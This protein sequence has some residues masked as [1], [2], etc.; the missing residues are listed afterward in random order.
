[1]KRSFDSTFRW[2]SF[3]SL[4]FAVIPSLSIVEA[5][6]QKL[7]PAEVVAK[8]LDSIGTAEAREAV[9]NMIVGG[10]VLAAYKAPQAAQFNGQSVVA[11]ARNKHVIGMGFEN[12]SYSQD[13]MA[14]DGQ[15]VTV[16]FARPGQRSN[17]GDF[18]LT[19]KNVM[20]DGLMGGALSNAWVLL[21][22]ERTPKLDYS[23]TK[24]VNGKPAHEL[25]Y[26]GKSSDLEIS[27]FFDAE[28]FRHIRTEYT[29]VITAQMGASVDA[30]GGQRSSR[31][32]MIEEF[33]DFKKEGD[34]TLPHTYKITLELDTR[35]GTFHANWTMDL[36]QFSYNK[37]IDPAMFNVGTGS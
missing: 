21:H 16:G 3:L 23:G 15:N 8:H 31:Y 18:I 9:E 12:S 36:N 30:S 14:Y 27:L 1:M 22:P 28:T 17:L 29:R 34:L 7:K 19:H 32:K 26:R 24:K 33:S 5:Q 37:D 10:T 4:L 35:G 13:N 6:G 11:S 2:L 20:R 25:K